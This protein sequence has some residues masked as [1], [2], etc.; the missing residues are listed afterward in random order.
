MK[1]TILLRIGASLLILWGLLN[2]VG[3]V[4]GSSEQPS[5]LVLYLFVIVGVLITTAGVGFWLFKKWATTLA[6]I[7]LV[8][9]SLIALYSASIL[10][11]L[12]DMN[13]SHHITRLV[14]S[15][16]IFVITILGKRRVTLHQQ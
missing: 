4:L 1:S 12:S 14:I 6:F 8:A 2:L 10:R 15:G 11:G 13:I 5:Q 3:G 7:S 9:L 16:V